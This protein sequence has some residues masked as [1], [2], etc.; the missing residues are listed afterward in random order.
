MWLGVQLK[1]VRDR[2]EAREKVQW[3]PAQ[4]PSVY[5]TPNSP[6][7]LRVLGERPVSFIRLS[8]ADTSQIEK[9]RRLFPEAQISYP[10]SPRSNMTLPPL[11]W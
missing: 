5:P 2:Q 6:W 10:S 11:R 8:V 3:L 7:S 1:W 4:V 9:Y